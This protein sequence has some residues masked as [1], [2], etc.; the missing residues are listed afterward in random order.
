MSKLDSVGSRWNSGTPLFDLLQYRGD[1]ATTEDCGRQDG[2][3]EK[4]NLL[5][6]S[7]KEREQSS[8]E[9]KQET[10]RCG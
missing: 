10:G 8:M 7:V 4:T 2:E 9:D 6:E 1:R 3:F 5:G